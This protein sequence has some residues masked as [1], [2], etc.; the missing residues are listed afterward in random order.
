MSVQV[1]RRRDTAANI[2]TFTPAQGEF[3]FDTT[4]NRII[5]GDGSTAGGWPAAKLSEV[6]VYLGAMTVS[7]LHALT[8]MTQGS[9]AIVTDATAP[10]WNAALTGSG[11]VHCPAVYVNGTWVAG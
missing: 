11:T 8:G 3:I 1:K 9:R 10:S 4:N 7:A 5:A 6:Q 2:A